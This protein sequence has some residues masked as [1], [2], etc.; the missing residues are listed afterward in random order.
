MTAEGTLV[1]NYI[2]HHVLAYQPVD[3]DAAQEARD[4]DAASEV[5]GF[6][7]LGVA[8]VDATVMAA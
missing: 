5:A 1:D 2:V 8:G 3:D 4:L 6:P 7:C